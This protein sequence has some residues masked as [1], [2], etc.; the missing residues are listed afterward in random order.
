[1]I[2]SLTEFQLS[3]L[4]RARPG[5]RVWE[6]AAALVAL[7]DELKTL[8]ALGLVEQD[9]ASGFQITPLGER[10]LIRLDIGS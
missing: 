10:T 7:L 9:E 3:I 4:R 5:L 8:T 2:H 6:A 1:M